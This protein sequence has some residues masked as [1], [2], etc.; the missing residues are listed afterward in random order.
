MCAGNKDIF[1]VYILNTRLESPHK[2]NRKC[3]GACSFLCVQYSAS[4]SL[5]DLAN[6]QRES[7]CLFLEIMDDAFNLLCVFN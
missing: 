2:V 5:P 6:L 1:Y 4:T 3:F 7:P